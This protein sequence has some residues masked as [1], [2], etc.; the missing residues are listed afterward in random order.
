MAVD[1]M[2]FGQKAL[3]KLH[4]M[5]CHLKIGTGISGTESKSI[6]KMALK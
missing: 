6:S 2:S 3:S 1:E 4:L 5:K